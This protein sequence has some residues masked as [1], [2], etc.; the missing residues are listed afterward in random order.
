MK[1]PIFTATVAVMS[2]LAG[3]AQLEQAEDWAQAKVLRDKGQEG[4]LQP[5][6]FAMSAKVPKAAQCKAPTS[7]YPESDNCCVMAKYTAAVDIDTAA[8]AARVEYG[9]QPKRRPD[10]G[11]GYSGFKGHAF[12]ANSGSFYRMF[13]EVTPRSDVR[14]S[15]GVWM[16]LVLSKASANRTNVE[17]LYCEIRGRVMKDQLTWHEA[18][19]ESI[20]ATIPPVKS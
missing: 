3:C 4:Q 19:Q 18:V 14:L 7:Q 1:L 10:E 20:R 9:F 2:A 6:P 11:T 12:E 16:G 5:E 13:G 17:P 8:A 15:R